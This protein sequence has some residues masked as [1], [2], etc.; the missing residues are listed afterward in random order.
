MINKKAIERQLK[1]MGKNKKWLA[2]QIGVSPSQITRLLSGEHQNLRLKHIA[3]IAY[4]LSTPMDKLIDSAGIW[5]G[6]K[7]PRRIK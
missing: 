7:K 6:V 2:R 1:R 4:V 3:R 5:E